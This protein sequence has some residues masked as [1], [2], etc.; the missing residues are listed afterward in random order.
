MGLAAVE[1]GEKRLVDIIGWTLGLRHFTL[2]QKQRVG[3]GI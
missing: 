2:A 1:G 3:E